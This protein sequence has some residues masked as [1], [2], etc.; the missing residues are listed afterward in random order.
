M[1]LR[2]QNERLAG[3][4]S[5]ACA[6]TRPPSARP[7]QAP[8]RE[9][10]R[11]RH[12]PGSGEPGRRA[13]PRPRRP[14]AERDPRPGAQRRRPAHGGAL[15][16][17]SPGRAS[18]RGEGC[19]ARSL[20]AAGGSSTRRFE[21]DEPGGRADRGRAHRGGGR[22]ESSRRPGAEVVDAS[23]CWVAP[24]FVDLHTHLRE[25]GQEYKED[26]ASGGR[27]AV[28]GGFTAVAC[29]ANTHPV[30]DDPATDR[31][32]PRPRRHDSPARVYPVAAATKGLEGE[33]MTE[34]A[35]SRGRRRRRLQRRRQDDH[36]QRRDAA[37]ARVLEAGRRP[38]IVHAEDRTLV[39]G[40]V[41]NEGPVSTRS[42]ACRATRPIA[43]TS[44]SSAT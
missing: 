20:I 9:G 30:N 27:A 39:G 17:A 34:M 11:D 41:V 44:T 2:I 31:L 10:R 35:A 8:L 25:P 37:R 43:E 18:P 14:P 24:G 29:M 36:G 15:P 5:R 26:I 16:L 28:A 13:L 33:V 21:R 23:G 12:A 32:H 19:V 7:R 38:V 6:S 42:S 40:G 22:P 3:P 1:A 4:S